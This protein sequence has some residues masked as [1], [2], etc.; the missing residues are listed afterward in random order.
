MKVERG[1]DSVRVERVTKEVEISLLFSEKGTFSGTSTLRFLDHLLNT[2]C[3]YS[4]LG[5]ELERCESKDGVLHHLVEDL[6][7]C[8]GAGLRELFDYS[9][10][11]RFGEATVP[12][13]E[14][15]VGCFL[16]LSGRCH[17]EGGY[18]FRGNVE[19]LPLEALEEFLRGFVRTSQINLHFVVFRSGNVHHTVEGMFKALGI[20]LK[21]ALEPT[22]RSSTKGVI[23]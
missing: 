22:N 5:I 10:L 9:K 14:S 18:D 17:F 6:G 16:D 4:G 8:V 15:L 11:S 19:D 12:M 2:L 1:R 3:H 13:D 7:M 20:A 21:R 23:D